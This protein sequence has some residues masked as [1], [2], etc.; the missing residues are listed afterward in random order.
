MRERFHK[1]WIS[2]TTT[3]HSQTMRSI[4]SLHR[5]SAWPNSFKP[6]E[7]PFLTPWLKSIS[8]SSAAITPLPNGRFG[9]RR[10]CPIMDRRAFEYQFHCQVHRS[11]EL[12]TEKSLIGPTTTTKADLG[13]SVWLHL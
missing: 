9:R 10:R 11:C 3:S 13:G 2:L 6:R 12:R 5:R 7:R 8:P 4:S 1:L